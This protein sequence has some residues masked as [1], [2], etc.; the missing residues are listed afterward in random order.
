M[1]NAYLIDEELVIVFKSS[2]DQ[3]KA[4]SY[5]GM[6]FEVKLKRVFKSALRVNF[7]LSCLVFNEHLVLRRPRYISFTL[8]KII[9]HGVLSFLNKGQKFSHLLKNNPHDLSGFWVAFS[10]LSNAYHIQVTLFLMIKLAQ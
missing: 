5:K 6:S 1:K 3:N 2:S 10:E 9:K 7:Y 8:N 4:S